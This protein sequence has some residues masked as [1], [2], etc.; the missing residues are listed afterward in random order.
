MSVSQCKGQRRRS[1]ISADGTLRYW[2][3]LWQ[4]ASWKQIHEHV[5]AMCILSWY[6]PTGS[7]CL[8]NQDLRDSRLKFELRL[9]C[10]WLSQPSKP[11]AQWKHQPSQI[12]DLEWLRANGKLRLKVYQTF[13]VHKLHVFCQS[14]PPWILHENRAESIIK[15]RN[16]EVQLTR[17][18]CPKG[19]HCTLA[20]S[21]GEISYHPAKY[22]TRVCNGALTADL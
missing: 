18:R 3:F 19:E 12:T 16:C 20:H 6:L 10:K 14:L 21:K 17:F 13:I 7:F 11:N 1:P 9:P 15:V 22:K 5:E 8:P 2:E 4:N